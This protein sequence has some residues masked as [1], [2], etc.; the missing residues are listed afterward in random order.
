MEVTSIWTSVLKWL[1]ATLGRLVVLHEL[2]SCYEM[3]RAWHMLRASNNHSQG[4]FSFFNNSEL[5]ANSSIK[6]STHFPQ[7]LPPPPRFSLLSVQI[8]SE[9]H[10]KSPPPQE[11]VN[12]FVHTIKSTY[13]FLPISCGE[14]FLSL[15]SQRPSLFISICNWFGKLLPSIDR[16]EDLLP[17]LQKRF[18]RNRV[19]GE[20]KRQ[21]EERCRCL[22]NRHTTPYHRVHLL[23][24]QA[25]AKCRGMHE[26][27]AGD[28]RERKFL[29]DS[30][31]SEVWLCPT[32][33]NERVYTPLMRFIVLY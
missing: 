21:K 19:E 24:A 31:L 5:P 29:L 16:Y 14:T 10:K 27:V 8:L 3:I 15:G 7:L 25:M 4:V 18:E 1:L 33:M 28:K 6:K 20:G 2:A 9:A 11:W 17:Q 22:R 12:F 23:V 26:K 13:S 32:K 30:R